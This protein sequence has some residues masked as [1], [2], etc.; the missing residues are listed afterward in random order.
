MTDDCKQV[1]VVFFDQ[2]LGAA[3]QPA[4]A[5][6]QPAGNAWHPKAG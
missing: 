2:L 3:D 6:D 4:G 5:A 1:I